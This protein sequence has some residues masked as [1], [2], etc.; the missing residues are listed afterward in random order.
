MPFVPNM[1]FVPVSKTQAKDQIFRNAIHDTQAGECPGDEFDNKISNISGSQFKQ[2]SIVLTQT[3]PRERNASEE[4]SKLVQGLSDPLFA[5]KLDK[6][7]QRHENISK[8]SLGKQGYTNDYV[9]A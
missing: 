4:H 8:L 1:K 2:R 7:E 3:S 9:S 5:S 6:M